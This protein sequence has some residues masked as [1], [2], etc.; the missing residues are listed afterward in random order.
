M[1]FTRVGHIDDLWSGEQT[2]LMVNGIQLLIINIDNQIYA[3]EDRCAHQGVPL[4]RG[5]RQGAVLTCSVHSWQYDIC[6]GQGINPKSAKLKMFPVKIEQGNIL[7]DTN[8][9]AL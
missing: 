1:T 7:V 4:S 6:T 5:C 9:G 8:E 2:T 3:L